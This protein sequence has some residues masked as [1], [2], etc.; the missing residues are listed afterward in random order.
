MQFDTQ[1]G[2]LTETLR[3]SFS[4]TVSIAFTPSTG[5][6]FQFSLH[7]CLLKVAVV[8]SQPV[9]FS[10]ATTKE[11]N[12]KFVWH[13][14]TQLKKIPPVQMKF[15]R[16]KLILGS[17]FVNPLSPGFDPHCWTISGAKMNGNMQFSLSAFGN[18]DWSPNKLTF[19]SLLSFGG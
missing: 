18:R 1:K 3:L 19:F 17:D 16:Q 6:Q 11:V 8:L 13:K 9:A 15:L 12:S 7:T 4:P 2:E 10:W 5:P 14:V